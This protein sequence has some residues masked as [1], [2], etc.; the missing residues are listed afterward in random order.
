MIENYI[1]WV[2]RV[3]VDGKFIATYAAGFPSH[4]DAEQAVS[5]ERN[6]AGEQYKAVDPITKDHGPKIDPHDVREI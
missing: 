2:V 1:G 5:D 4:V 3:I 6:K